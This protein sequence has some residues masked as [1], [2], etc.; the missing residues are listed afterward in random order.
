MNKI[1]FG[2][3]AAATVIA[4]VTAASAQNRMDR[5]WSEVRTQQWT[6]QQSWDSPSRRNAQ[7]YGNNIRFEASDRVK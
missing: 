3:L 1:V 6:M 2:A 4:S 5:N 7:S